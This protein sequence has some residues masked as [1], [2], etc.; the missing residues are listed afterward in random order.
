MVPSFS[1]ALMATGTENIPGRKSKGTLSAE[2]EIRW[3]AEMPVSYSSSDHGS[4][5]TLVN[6]PSFWFRDP[7]R[8]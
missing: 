8:Q 4:V 6:M 7:R 3:H 1:M 2:P 5:M